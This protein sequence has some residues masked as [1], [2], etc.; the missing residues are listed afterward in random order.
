MLLN[1]ATLV[2]AEEATAMFWSIAE[3]AMATPKFAKN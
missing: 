1:R 2:A 3:D